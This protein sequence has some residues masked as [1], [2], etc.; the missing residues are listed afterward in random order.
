MH[1]GRVR[2]LEFGNLLSCNS[3]SLCAATTCAAIYVCLPYTLLVVEPALAVFHKVRRTLSITEAS[4]QHMLDVSSLAPYTMRL[5][6]Q[7]LETGCVDMS[8][9]FNMQCVAVV[10][11]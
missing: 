3:I 5:A 2:E 1:G 11:S 10:S 9:T 4:K 8:V 7:F 6:S